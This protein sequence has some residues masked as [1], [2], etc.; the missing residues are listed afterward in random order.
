MFS[1]CSV[2][3][4]TLSVVE[5]LQGQVKEKE[6][7]VRVVER[8]RCQLEESD[9]GRREAVEKMRQKAA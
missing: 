4:E 7:E 9:K 8:Y 6:R 1:L 2:A 5:H 3:A